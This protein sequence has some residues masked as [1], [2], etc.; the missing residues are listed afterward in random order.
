MADTPYCITFLTMRTRNF[1]KGGTFMSYDV[2]PSVE[3]KTLLFL[4]EDSMILGQDNPLFCSTN[5][6]ESPFNSLSPDYKIWSLQNDKILEAFYYYEVVMNSE[7]DDLK[8]PNMSRRKANQML[9]NWEKSTLFQL[10]LRAKILIN[11]LSYFTRSWRE[12]EGIE[13]DIFILPADN[14]DKLSNINSSRTFSETFSYV[15]D[16]DGM[17]INA[18]ILN[19]SKSGINIHWARVIEQKQP[20]DFWKESLKEK[21]REWTQ[22][23]IK[24]KKEAKILVVHPNAEI[25]EYDTERLVDPLPSEII[26][27]AIALSSSEKINLVINVK[28]YTKEIYENKSLFKQLNKEELYDEKIEHGDVESVL[29]AAV[30]L[31]KTPNHIEEVRQEIPFQRFEERSSNSAPPSFKFMRSH[32]QA[33]YAERSDTSKPFIWE[34][35][36]IPVNCGA[37]TKTT[38]SPCKNL[39]GDHIHCHHHRT[40]PKLSV[41]TL[42]YSQQKQNTNIGRTTSLQS[43]LLKIKESKARLQK[44]RDA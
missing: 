40:Q 35:L 17:K 1:D 39:P 26:H 37:E 25:F 10:R 6:D 9:K 3:G 14:F 29:S 27:G 18:D 44:R 15:L 16:S 23:F 30:Y 31:R 5:I 33:L 32:L 42:T 19:K 22:N 12:N 28:K 20:T 41:S 34:S 36:G 11:I 2:N 43:A 24:N 38:D 13:S 21:H 7:K 4:I 8:L